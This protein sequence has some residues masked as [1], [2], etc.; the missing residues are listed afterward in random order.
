[1]SEPL[2]GM[3][4]LDHAIHAGLLLAWFVPAAPA[5]ASASSASTSACA[6]V[7]RAERRHAGVP[8]PA[9]DVGRALAYRTVETNFTLALADLSTRL[10]RRSLVVLL[11][12]FVDAVTAELMIENVDAA[13]APPPRAVRRAARPGA[14]TRSLARAA[15]ARATLHRAVVA[16]DFIREREVVLERLA[17]RRRALH[18][19]RAGRVLDGARQPLPRHQAPGARLMAAD[20]RPS[21]DAHAR[22]PPRARGDVAGARAPDR[23]A[24]QR[25]L[26][27]LDRRASSRACRT[28]TA[29]RCRRCR[30]ARDL[31]RPEPRRVPREPRGARVLRRLRHARSAARRQL[32]R[33]LRVAASRG[34]PRRR[35][36]TSLLAVVACSS[37]RSPRS[38]S[39]TR[40]T[41]DSSTRSSGDMAQGRDPARRPRSCATG[42]TTTAA[43]SSALAHVRGLALLAQRAVGILASRSGSSPACRRL[44]APVLERPGARRVR[45]ALRTR[46]ASASTSGAGS[47]PTASPS[48]SRSSCAAP[49]GFV[50]AHGLVFPGRRTRLDNLRERGARRRRARRSA[51]SRCCSSPALI[52][53]IFRQT[54]TDMPR[55]LRAS[56]ARTARVVDLATSAS[57]AARRS[58]EPHAHGR[59][60]R[61]RGGEPR[62]PQP[63]QRV[64]ALRG[65]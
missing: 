54:V 13:R 10:R 40:A 25:G 46:A 30:R 29:R 59:G 57:S 47:C 8:P 60:A 27:A 14:R 21:H 3:P 61:G 55:P 45:R 38:S 17:A 64:A 36:G 2:G 22:V 63:P 4:R 31:A 33:V 58:R 50:L 9:G 20:P 7:G 34:G 6:F 65:A 15:H 44:P 56:R 24:E 16:G 5:T 42:S 18:R 49:A 52:E 32:A 62:D 23:H 48:C 35:G 43:A 19:R 41:S 1:M 26:R 37:A 12:D 28:S 53:G 39:M 51:P 11:T